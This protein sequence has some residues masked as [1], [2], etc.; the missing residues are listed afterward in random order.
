LKDAGN[1]GGILRWNMTQNRG[2]F[3]MGWQPVIKVSVTFPDKKPSTQDQER[4]PTY[5]ET[6]GL[7]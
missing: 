3:W 2:G 7:G 4:V 5:E 6:V 1:N